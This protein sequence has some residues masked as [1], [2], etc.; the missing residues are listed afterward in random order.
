MQQ[1]ASFGVW[2]IVIKLAEARLEVKHCIPMKETRTAMGAVVLVFRERFTC[3][4]QS[5]IAQGRMVRGF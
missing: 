1:Q 2:T 5:R 4:Q 3:F